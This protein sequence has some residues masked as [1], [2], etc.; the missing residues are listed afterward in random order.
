V[1]VKGTVL[2]HGPTEEVF[3]RANLEAAFGGVLRHFTLGGTD[4]HDDAD[5][6]RVTILTDDE[7]P[8]VRYG[9]ET[10]TSG[11]GR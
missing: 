4:L 3:T 10:R 8:L 9:G 11:S 6:R 1:L 2:A 7:R 5:E